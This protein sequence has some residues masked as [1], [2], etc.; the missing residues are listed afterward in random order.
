MAREAR[1]AGQH[2]QFQTRQVREDLRSVISDR[3]AKMES[4][5]LRAWVPRSV[6][7]SETSPNSCLAASGVSGGSAPAPFPCTDLGTSLAYGERGRRTCS[8]PDRNSVLQPV[9]CCSHG[10]HTI[11]TNIYEVHGHCPGTTASPG[12]P[13]TELPESRCCACPYEISRS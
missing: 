2:A 3:W 12:Y 7:P 11:T 13:C 6:L 8:L 1:E 10:R 5:H 9:F 4:W